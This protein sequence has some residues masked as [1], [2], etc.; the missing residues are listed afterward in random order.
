MA[1][2]DP[3]TAARRAAAAGAA[4]AAAARAAA[5]A[6]APR[7]AR[8]QRK[9]Y[10]PDAHPP[11]A[12]LR[13]AVLGTDPGA[14]AA[15]AALAGELRA[16]SRASAALLI[17]WPPVARAQDDALTAAQFSLLASHPPPPPREGA[18][19]PGAI[20]ATLPARRLAARLQARGLPAVARGRLA[21]LALG[22][23]PGPAFAAAERA[24]GALAEPAVLALAAPR[25]REATALLA[26]Q[27]LIAVAAPPG[28]S[29]DL[30][31]LAKASLAA[32]GVPV[33]AV[34]PPTRGPGR[35]LALAGLARLRAGDTELRRA[36]RELR[37][38]AGARE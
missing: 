13:A 29:G 2:Q 14:L 17:T 31:A 6:P 30:L 3:R 37:A 18:S 27:H 22:P 33:V 19:A 20:P 8:R 21:W 15:G 23:D 35:L 5:N 34:R 36:V 12:P 1:N 24:L 4:P 11:P 26:E 25:P 38:G 16:R 9:R 7:T 10:D 28:A 32:T